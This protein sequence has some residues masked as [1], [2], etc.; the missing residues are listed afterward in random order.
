MVLAHKDL[1]PHIS[2]HIRAQSWGTLANR[3]FVKMNGLGKR[4][5]IVDLRRRRARSR[6]GEARAAAR[7][8]PY[9]Q[10]MA[11]YPGRGAIDAS[12]RISQQ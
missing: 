11:L 12:I 10:L 5:V 8:G 1:S 2:P 9:D 4:I 7:A 6:A 3:D